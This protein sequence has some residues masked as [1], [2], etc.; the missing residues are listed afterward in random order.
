MAISMMEDENEKEPS[1][2]FEI[3]EDYILKEVIH[4]NSYTMVRIQK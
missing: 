3:K 4:G 1:D 2:P